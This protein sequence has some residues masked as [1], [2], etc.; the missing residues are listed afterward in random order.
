[1]LQR[2]EEKALPQ[3]SYVRPGEKV[4]VGKETNNPLPRQIK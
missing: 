4:E 3:L 2:F 1:M